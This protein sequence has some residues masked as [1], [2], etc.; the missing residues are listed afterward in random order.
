MSWHFKSETLYGKMH[1]FSPS[2]IT[3][4]LAHIILLKAIYKHTLVCFIRGT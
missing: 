4:V 3:L 2:L 1:F